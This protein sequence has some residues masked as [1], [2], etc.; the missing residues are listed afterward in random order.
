MENI[1]EVSHLVKT[2]PP[3]TQA[4]KDFSIKI[5]RG[6][7]FGLGPNGSG[8]TSLIRILVG[9]LRADSETMSVIDEGLSR[10]DRFFLVACRT[11]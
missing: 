1:V 10:R 3:K 2:S 8:K 5:R 4:L 9:V 7:T 6:I 11:E